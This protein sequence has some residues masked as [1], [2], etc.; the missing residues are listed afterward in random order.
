MSASNRSA[1]NRSPKADA[2]LNKKKELPVVKEEKPVEKAVKVEDKDDDLNRAEDKDDN[3]D[4][5]E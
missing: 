3:L 4:I 1:A 2:T 5:K